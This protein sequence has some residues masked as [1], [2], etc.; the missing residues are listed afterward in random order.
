MVI[1]LQHLELGQQQA[2]FNH[3][4]LVSK[5]T[6]QELSQWLG[7]MWHKQLELVLQLLVLA[8]MPV[9]IM[10]QHGVTTVQQTVIMQQHLVILLMQQVIIQQP[11][12]VIQ[13]Q[14]IPIAMQLVHMAMNL[15]VNIQV[16]SETLLLF[17]LE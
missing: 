2:V 12:V 7:V 1:P 11:L 8:Q 3:Q 5:Q 14:I 13:L 6:H 16:Q 4:H 9:V 15:M 10:Q 17:H